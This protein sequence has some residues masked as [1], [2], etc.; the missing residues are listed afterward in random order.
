MSKNTWTVTAKEDPE[1]GDIMIELPEELLLQVGWKEGDILDWKNNGD[2][3]FTLTK[4][5][6]DDTPTHE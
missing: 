1:T 6:M 4:K 2:G 5:T 3:S